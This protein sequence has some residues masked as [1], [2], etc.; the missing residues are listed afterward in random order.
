MDIH[1]G[2][3]EHDAMDSPSDYVTTSF[4][5]RP[6]TP[7]ANLSILLVSGDSA[8]EVAWSPLEGIDVARALLV[9]VCQS[10]GPFDLTAEEA[11]LPIEKTRPEVRV[12]IAMAMLRDAHADLKQTPS[13]KPS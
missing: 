8:I 7:G 13:T 1:N 2:T 6:T 5:V 9:G 12:A 11:H 10:I 3:K 4:I